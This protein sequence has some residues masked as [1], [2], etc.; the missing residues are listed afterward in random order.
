MGLA[1]A[2]VCAGS[3]GIA[4]AV[5][6]F[7]LVGGFE[8]RFGFTSQALLL[9]TGEFLVLS[10]VLLVGVVDGLSLGLQLLHVGELRLHGFALQVGLVLGPRG[11]GGGDGAPLCGE[12]RAF[13]G[14]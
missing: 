3:P 13:V 12:G 10:K 5:V 7:P 14:S 9:L 6:F 8:K 2:G 4:V 11:I 1:A